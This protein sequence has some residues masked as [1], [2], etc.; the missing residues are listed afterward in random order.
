[1]LMMLVIV[2]ESDM[3]TD[4]WILISE[5]RNFGILFEKIKKRKVRVPNIEHDTLASHSILDL[6]LDFTC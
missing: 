3:T 2:N 4:K 5:T 6:D 1:M